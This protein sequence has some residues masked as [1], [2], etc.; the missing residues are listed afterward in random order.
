MLWFKN[1][2]V[3]M[4]NTI[5]A[6]S[7]FILLSLTT[8]AQAAKLVPADEATATKLCM[9]AVKGKRITMYK[10]L[11]AAGYTLKNFA[12]NIQCN[13][14]SILSFVEHNGKNTAGML[15]MLNR[16]RTHIAITDLAKNNAE[17]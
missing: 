1:W 8:N 10:E 7:G 6:I 11:K 12:D 9:T 14:E 15:K 16:K 3:M 4:K 5:L 2:R 17:K 13:G